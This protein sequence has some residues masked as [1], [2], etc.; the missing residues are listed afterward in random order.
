[1]KN[2]TAKMYPVDYVGYITDRVLERLGTEGRV[3][4]RGE[5]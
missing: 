2:V 1:M 3:A 4:E 5:D